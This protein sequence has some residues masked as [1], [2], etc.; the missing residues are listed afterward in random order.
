VAQALFGVITLSFLVP[1]Q[2]AAQTPLDRV[3]HAAEF[4]EQGK[5]H[6]AIDLLGPLL[7]SDANQTS[8]DLTGVAWNVQGLAYQGLGEYDMARRS[9]ETSI[10]IL[11]SLPRQRLQYA[12]ALNNLGSLDLDIGQ[13][14][15]SKSL[16]FKAKRIYE[17]ELNHEGTAQVLSKLALTS[18]VQDN[19]KAARL[20]LA[21]AFKEEDF[22]QTHDPVDLA[23]MYTIQ[24]SLNGRDKD[25]PAAM[26]SINHAIELWKQHFGPSYYMLAVG[27]SQ[28]GQIYD[29][30]GDYQH[31]SDDLLQAL[32]LLKRSS[33]GNPTVYFLAEV[34]Y[35]RIL[36][37]SGARVDAA[38]IESEARISLEALRHQQCGECTISAQGF[39]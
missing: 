27:Y 15:Q 21:Q 4:N 38:R 14:S 2:L 31:A 13:L 7:Q 26:S 1:C 37:D 34:E 6:A 24:C 39:K 5:F 32:A 11:R 25:F 23:T 16:R 12:S 8:D 30:L 18:L 28:R 20:Y 35:A 33:D 36:R 29:K 10:R 9:Y 3:G 19:R 22:S 17:L